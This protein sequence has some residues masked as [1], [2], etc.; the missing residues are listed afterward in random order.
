M[1]NLMS[2][3]HQNNYLESR[4]IVTVYDTEMSIVILGESRLPRHGPIR[5]KTAA[6][7]IL[8]LKLLYPHRDGYPFY[9]TKVNH[10]ILSS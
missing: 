10:L 2:M 6:M 1:F 7:V 3:Q 5:D 8:L 9:D 4:Q